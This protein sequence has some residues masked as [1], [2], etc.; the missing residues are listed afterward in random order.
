MVL[1]NNDNHWGGRDFFR[2]KC[3][4]DTNKKFLLSI[5][6]LPKYIDQVDCRDDDGLNFVLNQV[7]YYYYL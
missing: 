5:Q 3:L 4:L 2:S 6:L 1:I 7:Y